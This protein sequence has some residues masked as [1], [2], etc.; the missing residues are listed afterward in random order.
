MLDP[1]K[2]MLK[3]CCKMSKTTALFF[4][5]TSVLGMCATAFSISY[6][7]WL[8]ILFGCLTFAVMGLGFVVKRRGSGR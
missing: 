1:V 6:N 5:V 2:N 3:E 4:A 7:T 8:A